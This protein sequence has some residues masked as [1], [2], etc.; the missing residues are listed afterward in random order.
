MNIQEL[1]DL[2]VSSSEDFHQSRFIPWWVEDYEKFTYQYHIMEDSVVR[3]A[4]ACLA[5]CGKED[6]LAPAGKL[7]LTLFHLLV[8]HNFY[9]TVERLLSDGRIE[10]TEADMPD[11]GG[12][13]LTPLMLACARSNLAMVRLLLEHG[14]KDSFCDARGMN[15][16]H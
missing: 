10:D 2:L 6:L 5:E 8:W 4:K 12:H 13:G 14:A 11:H 9:D 16:C 7:G 3:D 1:T 15:Q